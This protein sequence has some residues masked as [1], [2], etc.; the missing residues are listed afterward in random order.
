MKSTELLAASAPRPRS[1]IH[2]HRRVLAELRRVVAKAK[3]A[4]EYRART[5][6]ERTW[7]ARVVDALEQ[8]IRE[9]DQVLPGGED[10]RDRARVRKRPPKMF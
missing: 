8:L 3:R 5:D 6:V 2:G 4:G 1:R 10:P 7:S 9:G